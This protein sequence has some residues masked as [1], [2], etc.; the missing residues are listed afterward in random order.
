MTNPDAAPI[1]GEN[2]A[3]ITRLNDEYERQPSV[4][5]A[6]QLGIAY[7]NDDNPGAAV[8]WFSRAM[9]LLQ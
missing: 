5:V 2:T 4:E 9:E 7:F 3:T 6:N 8:E 1:A